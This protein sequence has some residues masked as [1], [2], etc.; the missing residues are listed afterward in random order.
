[1]RAAAAVLALAAV[2][3]SPARAQ[4]DPACAKFED[5]LAYNACLASRGPRAGAIGK[6][7]G[8]AAP[9]HADPEAG[10]PAEARKS[11]APQAALPRGFPPVDRRHGRVH[12]EFRLR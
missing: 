7:T 12:M 9:G 3:P 11:A 2:L 1:M 4:D 8:T 5:P 10:V 6:E